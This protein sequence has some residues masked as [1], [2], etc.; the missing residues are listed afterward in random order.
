MTRL[1]NIGPK[2][3]GWLRAVGIHTR[4]DL[5]RLGTAEVFLRL[6]RSGFGV[7]LNAAYAIE[8]ALLDCHW[9]DLP[10]ELRAVLRQDIARSGAESSTG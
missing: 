8:A 10:P 9:L 2:T 5:E 4:A 7:S 1:R 6:K 3:A